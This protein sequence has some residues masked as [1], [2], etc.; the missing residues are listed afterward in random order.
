MKISFCGLAFLFPLHIYLSLVSNFYSCRAYT[1]GNQ[2][3]TSWTCWSTSLLY[4]FC[5]Y[6]FLLCLLKK[7]LE[8]YPFKHTLSIMNA[9]FLCLASSTSTNWLVTAVLNQ[10][11]IVVAGIIKRVSVSNTK[12]SDMILFILTKIT[13][14]SVLNQYWI[15][16]FIWSII[17]L[18]ELFASVQ[19]KVYV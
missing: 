4:F 17:H 11:S 15:I 10:V 7:S 8:L 9:F 1:Y 3:V 2:F 19:I 6:S 18:L 14:S 5:F 12:W 16:S 13:S